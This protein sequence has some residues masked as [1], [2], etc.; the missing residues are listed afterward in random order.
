[1]RL[2]LLDWR[3]QVARLYAD[4]RA[5]ADP[6]DGHALRRAGRGRLFPEHPDSPLTAPARA[7]FTGLAVAPYAPGMRFE[8]ELAT[9]AEPVRWEFATEGD[10]VV[11]F[12]RI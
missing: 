9:T 12:S 10:G 4:V 6:R 3:R 5:A 2:T 8:V 7:A 1:M 11:P